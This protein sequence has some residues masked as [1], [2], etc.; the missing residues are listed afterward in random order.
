MFAGTLGV[1]RLTMRAAVRSRLVLSLVVLLVL[2][3]LLLPGMIKGDG[4]LPGRIR[5]LLYYTLGFAAWILSLSTLWASAGAVSQEIEEKSIQLLA[6]KPVRTFQVWLGK[7]LGLLFLNAALLCL[8]GAIIWISVYRLTSTY[9]GAEEELQQVRNEILVSRTPVSARE[10]RIVGETRRRLM[11]LRERG[12]IPPQVPDEAALAVIHRQV[13]AEQSVVA[14]G[15]TRQWIFDIPKGLVRPD[16][17]GS[18]EQ[19]PPITLR[20]RLLSS[21]RERLAVPGTWRIG[22]AEQPDIFVLETE[23]APFGVHQL[24]VSSPA[25]LDAV[26]REIPLRARYTNRAEPGH[27]PAAFAPKDG[28]VLLFRSGEFAGNF[29]RAVIVLLFALAALAALG[30]TAG[31]IFSFPVATFVASACVVILAVSHFLVFTTE[32]D[33]A[34]TH[35]HN[36]NEQEEP[37]RLLVLGEKALGGLHQVAAPAMNFSPL[38]SLSDGRRISNGD[39]VRAALILLIAYPAG[40]WL[41][42]GILLGRRELALPQ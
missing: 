30:L 15:K 4:T 2:V 28:I 26:R 35:N 41:A 36:G 29:I 10:P 27:S 24:P 18:A 13:L 6:A 12:N 39:V 32:Q 17:N 38:S 25:L 37:S 5:V 9:Q 34:G 31:A 14:P 40:L 8:A 42:G 3:T 11:R 20:Y 23:D 22:T 19:A 33:P 1:A 16:M 21:G 7:W